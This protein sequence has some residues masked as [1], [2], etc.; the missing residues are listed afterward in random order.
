MVN[1]LCDLENGLGIGYGSLVTLF[2]QGGGGGDEVDQARNERGRQ[3]GCICREGSER[4]MI[5]QHCITL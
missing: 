1:K 4:N 3:T 5:M 2:R